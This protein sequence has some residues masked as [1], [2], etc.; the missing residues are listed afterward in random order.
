MTIQSCQ[1]TNSI[2]CINVECGHD[3]NIPFKG[4][5][6]SNQPYDTQHIEYLIIGFMLYEPQVGLD[7][8]TFTKQTLE[9]LHTS[10]M[11]PI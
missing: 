3:R 2:W 8:T 4:H 9:Y 1:L 6:D 10:Q 7:Y 5:I 11:F